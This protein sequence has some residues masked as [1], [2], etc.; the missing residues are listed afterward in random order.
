MT[1][2]IAVA[3]AV[4]VGLTVVL[5]S[6]RG[7]GIPIA[8]A[9]ALVAVLAVAALAGGKLY[10]LVEQRGFAYVTWSNLVDGF[11]YPGALVGLLL[12]LVV[13]RRL[14]MP[15]VS[16]GALGDWLAPAM[17]F[18]EVAGRIGCF[19]NGCC[20]G[21]P[22][23]APWCVAF[24]SGSIPHNFQLGAGLIAPDA[25]ASLPVHPLQLYFAAAGLLATG[26]A[27]WLG[28]RKRYDGQVALVALVVFLVPSAAAELVRADYLST[29][30]E[31]AG[32]SQLVWIGFGLALASVTALA[33]CEIAVR[34]RLPAAHPAQSLPDAR[35]AR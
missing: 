1:T 24:P 32:V 5:A 23:H 33:L 13:A 10:A 9:V 20:F 7:A 4:V 22:C 31:W 14:L 3:G 25:G 29:A 30:Y 34:R 27:L 11:R 26:T 15:T 19:L 35:G 28:P 16:L 2:E 6:A 18:A 12:G 8:R 21:V 17:G